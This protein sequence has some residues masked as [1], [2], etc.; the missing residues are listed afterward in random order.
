[1]ACPIFDTD[2]T[3]HKE[4]SLYFNRYQPGR[5]AKF[6]PSKVYILPEETPSGLRVL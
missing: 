2:I 1:M 4:Y 5:G 6:Y 3:I